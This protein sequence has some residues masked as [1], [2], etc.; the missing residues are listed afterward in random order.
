[1]TCSDRG[2]WL[3]GNRQYLHRN[4][5]EQRATSSEASKVARVLG[6]YNQVS[7]SNVYYCQNKFKINAR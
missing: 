2:R 7:R 4:R 6:R 1:M 5:V 3:P